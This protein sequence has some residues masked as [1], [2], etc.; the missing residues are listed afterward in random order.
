[1]NFS[2][3]LS[4]FSSIDPMSFTTADVAIVPLA[5]CTNTPWSFSK[6]FIMASIVRVTSST[7]FSLASI[8][9]LSKSFLVL[10]KKSNYKYFCKYACHPFGYVLKGN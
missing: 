6:G 7:A 3:A 5:K 2:A 1:M 8:F 9:V 4:P 10:G